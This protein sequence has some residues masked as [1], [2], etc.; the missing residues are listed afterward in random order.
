MPELPDVEVYRRRL[1]QGGLNRTIRKVVVTDARILDDVSAAA[2]ARRLTG[3]RFTATG[4]HGK[5]LLVRLDKGGWL[6]MHFG[7]TGAVHH[8]SNAEDAP[9]YTRVRFDFSDRAHL[10][11]TSKRMLGHVGLAD[12]DDAFAAEH[13]LGPDALAREVDLARFKEALT[14]TRRPV[15]SALMD[16]SVLAGIGNVYSDEMLFH[17]RI[18][19]RTPTD[20]LGAARLRRL[21]RTMHRVLEDAIARGAG[22]DDFV[23]RV[24]RGWLLRQRHKGGR[25]PRG[26]GPLKT[27]RIGGRT[28]YFCPA[29]QR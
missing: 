3:R 27:L 1:R 5:N 2:L 15:K 8:F 20:R 9:R 28:S 11:Y 23:E 25:C 10:A 16:Q 6:R 24:P 13:D 21:Y 29:C 14:G 19:P 18:D 26:H 22:S 7:M 17:A 12:D 4:R